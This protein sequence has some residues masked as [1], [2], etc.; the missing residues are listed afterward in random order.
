[1]WR[2]RS[3][4]TV[5]LN[6][7]EDTATCQILLVNKMHIEAGGTARFNNQ[8]VNI[9]A[10]PIA[11][12]PPQHIPTTGALPASSVVARGD[13]PGE[14]GPNNVRRRFGILLRTTRYNYTPES[15]VNF[16]RANSDKLGADLASCQ[17]SRQTGSATS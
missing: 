9:R 8:T 1:M 15:R 3:G 13:H 16:W 6:P 10:F 5:L 7:I 4:I 2:R 12:V 11:D 14:M 17:L